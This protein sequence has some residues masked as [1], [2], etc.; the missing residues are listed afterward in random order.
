[1]FELVNEDYYKPIRV[2]NFYSNNY[3]E[4]ERD[5]DKNLS[6]EEY[7]NKVNLNLKVIVNYKFDTWKIP[8]TITIYFFQGYQQRMNNAFKKS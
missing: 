3:M 1:M 4:Y 6:I 5:R 8:I 2:S 7:L